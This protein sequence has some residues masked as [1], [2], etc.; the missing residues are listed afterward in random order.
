MNYP[1]KASL[2]SAV[3]FAAIMVFALYVVQLLVFPADSAG[4]YSRIVWGNAI[5]PVILGVFLI[6]LYLLWDKRRRLT[7]EK[8]KSGWFLQDIAP[9]LLDRYTRIDHVTEKHSDLRDNL[10]ANRWN[11]TQLE[12]GN[13][14]NSCLLYTS[15]S[16]RDLSTSRMP[17]SA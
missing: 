8:K 5:S 9:R 3:L 6:A 7:K 15:P 14:N 17:S 2:P 13:Q 1:I 12:A 10:L 4:L 16:P 11:R